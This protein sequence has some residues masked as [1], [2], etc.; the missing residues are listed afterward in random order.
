MLQYNRS[1]TELR[2]QNVKIGQ[3]LETNHNSVYGEGKKVVVRTYSDETLDDGSFLMEVTLV[4][5][6]MKVN[7][8]SNHFKNPTN[9]ENY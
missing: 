2:R 8:L 6:G 1:L 5:S 7:I 4:I 3:T 9:V